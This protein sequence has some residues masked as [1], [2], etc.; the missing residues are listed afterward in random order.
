MRSNP[1]LTNSLRITS[2]ISKKTA[3]GKH[4]VLK[5]YKKYP[6]Y[7][8]HPFEPIYWYVKSWLKLWLPFKFRND[9]RSKFL[10]SRNR[11][12]NTE[13]PGRQQP[14]GST[15]AWFHYNSVQNFLACN[16]ARVSAVRLQMHLSALPQLVFQCYTASELLHDRELSKI[17]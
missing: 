10:G 2:K 7:F 16:W 15:E 5:I 8:I 11:I 17:S 1:Q 12:P 6:W 9:I 4:Y 14:M 13:K 3:K